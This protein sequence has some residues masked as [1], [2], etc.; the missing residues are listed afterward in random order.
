MQDGELFVTGRIK[1]LIIVR[2]VN[3]YPQ[4]IEATVERSHRAIFARR[5][6]RVHRGGGGPRAAGHR[7]RDRTRS[8]SRPGIVRADHRRHPPRRFGRARIAGRR[9]RA[10]QGGQ[11]SQDVERQDSAARR[12]A[13]VSSTARCEV[14]RSMACLGQAPSYR[15][16]R[17]VEPRRASRQAA[18]STNGAALAAARPRAAFPKR[19]HEIVLR[20]SAQN[21]QG[22]AAQGSRWKPTSSSLGSTRSSEWRSS[23]RSKTLSAAGSPSRCSSRWKPAARSSS[24]RD[25]PGQ[26]ASCQGRSRRVAEVPPENYRFELYPEYLALKQNMRALCRHRA[27]STRT[28]TCTN[29]SPTTPR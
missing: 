28:S 11:H 9:G 26:N 13:P 22:D 25:L 6:R 14:V 29:A 15:P 19:P 5:R 8:S 20:R 1:D 24:R 23:P 16:K 21:R 18:V 10:A 7:G 12:R 27:W 2:G 4:D 17:T 3:H